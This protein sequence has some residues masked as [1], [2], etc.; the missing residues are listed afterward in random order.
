[1]GRYRVTLLSRA[2][3]DET[4]GASLR[5]LEKTGAI[6]QSPDAR[7]LLREAGATVLEKEV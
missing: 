6:I 4:H 2:E 3:M 5:I 1:M 7:K